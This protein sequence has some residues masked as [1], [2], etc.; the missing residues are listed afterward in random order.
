MK[1]LLYSPVFLP[2]VGGLEFNVAH[3]ADAFVGAGHEVV[4]V[5]QTPSAAPDAARYCV[6]RRPGRIALLRWVRWCDI[7][8]QANVSL[9]GWWPM[10]LV[11]RPWVVS[12]H[13]WYSRPDGRYALQDRI[14]RWLLRYAAASIAVSEA[15]GRDLE[16]PC[17]VIPN[18]YRDDLFR[19][20]PGV[21]RANDVLFVG[22]LVS[23]KGVD[24]L[25]DALVLLAA[26][27]LRPRLSIVGEGPERPL[28]EAQVE[29]SEL[30]GQVRFLGMHTGEPLVQLMNEHRVLVVPSRY[31]E[32]FGIVALEGIACGCVVIGSEGGGLKE[33]IG[34]CGRTFPNGD[35]ARLASLIETTLAA[36]VEA[37]AESEQRVRRHLDAHS[38]QTTV[39]KYLQVLTAV[40][41]GLWPTSLQLAP[42]ADR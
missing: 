40:H 27:G 29:R 33:A 36:P 32:P 23:D 18:S 42:S 17:V 41:A 16:T 24:L 14:K 26:R 35:V 30:A 13:G 7:F 38:T 1:I 2:H 15:I 20:L 34:D 11:R 6:V 31:D 5:T 10:L 39:A 22:R 21:G 9:R 25:V 3:L 4:V 12:H 37:S 8:F 19:R 28:L